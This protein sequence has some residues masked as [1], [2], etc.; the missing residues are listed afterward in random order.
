[1]KPFA[2]FITFL[3][4]TMTLLSRSYKCFACSKTFNNNQSRRQHESLFRKLEG[5]AT[6]IA[7][8]ISVATRSQFKSNKTAV[9]LRKQAEE[10]LRWDRA[11]L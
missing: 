5:K 9:K 3:L 11:D 8:V 1:M 10:D 6:F 2:L 7:T 4:I